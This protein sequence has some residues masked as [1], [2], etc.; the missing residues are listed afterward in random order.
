MTVNDA[1]FNSWLQK[2]VRVS[3]AKVKTSDVFLSI[4]TTHYERDPKAVL[5]FG[6]AILLDKPIFVVAPLGTKIPRSVQRI[7][8]GINF[9]DPASEKSL[10][11]AITG[12]SMAIGEA[13]KK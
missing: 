7:A 5:E 1:D 11:D 8:S 12:L 10:E 2:V 3:G 4:F 9:F 13:R 6:I